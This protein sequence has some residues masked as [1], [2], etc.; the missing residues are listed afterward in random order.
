MWTLIEDMDLRNRIFQEI[1]KRNMESIRAGKIVL[2]FFFGILATIVLLPSIMGMIVDGKVTGE[3]VANAL[4]PL[5]FFGAFFAFIMYFGTKNTEGII[6][7][8]RNCP[9]YYIKGQILEKKHI[10]RHKKSDKIWYNIL[11]EDNIMYE[12]KS[13][14]TNNTNAFKGRPCV[15]IASGTEAIDNLD[16]Y[17]GGSYCITIDDLFVNDFN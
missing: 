8:W 13:I 5:A 17:H 10:R 16:K 2:G 1:Y 9:I 12:C 11:V 4:I 15:I 6:E 7:N 3:A 14:I